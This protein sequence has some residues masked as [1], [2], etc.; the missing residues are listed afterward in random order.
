M[1]FSDEQGQ[2]GLT[3]AI[4]YEPGQPFV[5]RGAILKNAIEKPIRDRLKRLAARY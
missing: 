2:T 1:D 4:G 3:D 5:F